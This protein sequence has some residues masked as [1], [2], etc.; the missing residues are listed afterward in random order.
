MTPLLRAVNINKSF[1]TPREIPILKDVSLDVFP[2]NTI[3]ITGKSGQGKSTL[4][5]ILGTLEPPC[6]G[7]LEIAGQQVSR[8]TKNLLRNRHIAFIFQSFHLLEDYT[9]LENVL[10]PA[11]IARQSTRKGSQAYERANHLLEKVGLSS[12]AHHHTKFLSGGEKQRVAIAR[13]LC[14]DPNILFADEPSGNLDKQTS[15][16][17]H[18]LLIDFVTSRPGKALVVVTHNPDLAAM[19]Q[20]EYQITCGSIELIK[21]LS[22]SL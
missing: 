1:Y 5:Q 19:C 9:A 21:P 15:E 10:M 8:S 7:S 16:V 18:S 11:S 4:L 6:S 17:I 20:N 12:R 14:N 2:G 3:A 13:A 22:S